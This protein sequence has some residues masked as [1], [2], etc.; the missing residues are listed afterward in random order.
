MVA[1]AAQL[2]SAQAAELL[3]KRERMMGSLLGFAENIE[4]PGAPQEGDEILDLEDEWGAHTAEQGPDGK[5]VWKEAAAPKLWTPGN[6]FEPVG[7]A[8]AHHHRIMCEAIQRTMLR[9]YGRLIMLAPPGSAKS[10][11]CTVV[12][13]SWYIH[14][15]ARRRIILASYATPLA[16]KHGAK[17]RQVAGQ[18]LVRGCFGTSLSKDTSA[19]EMWSLTNGSEY[20]SGGLLSGI[21]GN[22]CFVAGTM[23]RGKTGP[24][25]IEHVYPSMEVLA[26]DHATDRAVYRRVLGTQ[27]TLRADLVRVRT[28]AG[29]EFVCTADHPIYVAG[30]GYTRASELVQGDACLVVDAALFDLRN[31]SAAP[32]L[33]VG[34]A[35]P[36]G[37][38][39][40]VLQPRVHGRE[41]VQEVPDVRHAGA[42]GGP[43]TQRSILQRGVSAAARLSGQALR[44]VRHAVSAKRKPSRILQQALREP[45]ARRAHGRLRE[46]AIQGW[47]LVRDVVSRNAQGDSSARSQPLRGVRVSEE[48]TCAPHRRK[49]AEQSRGEPRDALRVV[50]HDAPQVDHDTV[51]VVEPVRAGSVPVYDLEIEGTSNFFAASVLSHNCH[52]IVVD[53]P[54]KGREAADSEAIR[55][56]TWDAWN[57][58]LMTRLIPGGFVILVQTRWSHEDVAGKLLGRNYDGRSGPVLCTDG[59][60]WEVLNIPAEC[61][62]SDDPLGRPIGDGKGGIPGSM[63]WPE[64]FDAE[65]WVQ[66]RKRPR[67]WAAL[68]QQRPDADELKQFR[69]EWFEGGTTTF[70]DE[71]GVATEKHHDC[72]RYTLGE[73]PRWLNKYSSSDYATGDDEGDNTEHG[74]FGLDADGHIWV[75]DW[76]H[77]QKPTD[78][79]MNALLD[80]ARLHKCRNGFSES[81]VIKKAIGPFWEEQQV[82]KKWPMNITYLPTV[83]Q[84]NKAARCKSFREMAEAGRIHI[85][86]CAW[87]DRLLAQLLAFPDHGV[88]DD[89]V[90]VCGLIGR[91]LEEM[92]WSRVEEPTPLPPE[93]VPFTAAW[94]EYGTQP[95]DKPAGGRRI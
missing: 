82:H 60:V 19:K 5:T 95:E 72:T 42:R 78:I 71:K 69:M 84:G 57:D 15:F 75:L 85:P 55:R 28:V 35:G 73:H 66:F 1:I 31:G 88:P 37:D 23:L 63:L 90:D 33:R 30:K 79:G 59:R 39:R 17:A 80:M 44:A 51:S 41:V 46:L 18:A 36:E 26:Y 83:G 62:R 13:P 48:A 65:H 7:S 9:R 54:I 12:G 45:R 92:L 29:R 3:L 27:C 4:I 61:E 43:Q 49:P 25:S 77:A 2:T 76:W 8:M 52:G 21:T 22:R 64:W 53:D 20:M 10:S 68:F 34:E 70:V 32:E 38:Q 56:A 86:R 6:V 24:V 67:T 81:G 47:K 93:L 50:P 58:D 91:G 16:A 11:Y 40:R 89:A 74:M 94:L 87:G 14:R